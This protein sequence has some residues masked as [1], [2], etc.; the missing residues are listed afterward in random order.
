MSSGK[1]S[2]VQNAHKEQNAP[3][4]DVLRVGKKLTLRAIYPFDHRMGTKKHFD[5]LDRYFPAI[6]E[7]MADQKVT[8]ALVE[9]FPGVPGEMNARNV[10]YTNADEIQQFYPPVIQFIH[11]KI[12]QD[13]TGQSVYVVDPARSINW[14]CIRYEPFVLPTVAG[15]ALTVK[16][17]EELTLFIDHNPDTI[18]R[19]LEMTRVKRREVF[20]RG[21]RL[22]VSGLVTTLPPYIGVVAGDMQKEYPN[23]QM[24]RHIVIA[25]AI[26]E[27]AA[28]LDA[29]PQ[30]KAEDLLVLY[31]SYHW[32]GIRSFLEHPKILD[33]CF[34]FGVKPFLG[35]QRFLDNFL[36]IRKYTPTP[37]GWKKETAPI[38]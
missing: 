22:L 5:D 33:A 2:S 13:K 28:R 26:Q 23:E 3:S 20:R 10:P 14:G 21:A 7:Q 34:T 32:K 27:I 19:R 4:I 30:A 37:Q 12:M 31:P 29:D 1:E 38:N 6:K 35:A 36:E 25:K 9:Y 11:E 8:G 18:K 24:L 17:M 16:G 15:I